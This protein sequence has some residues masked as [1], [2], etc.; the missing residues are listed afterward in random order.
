VPPVTN[1]ILPAR[2]GISL[3]GSK[4]VMPWVDCDFIFEFKIQYDVH[5]TDFS[6]DG[7]RFVDEVTGQARLKVSCL[8]PCRTAPAPG[9]ILQQPHRN[10][11]I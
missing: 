2:D 8:L 11:I 3:R 1:K 7:S 6:C 5:W 4:S 10:L 9:Y